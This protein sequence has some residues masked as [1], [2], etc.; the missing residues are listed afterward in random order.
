MIACMSKSKE[1]I[2]LI[3]KSITKFLYDYRKYIVYLTLRCL[4]LA[5]C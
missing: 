3:L 1:Q 2:D 4:R 5:L